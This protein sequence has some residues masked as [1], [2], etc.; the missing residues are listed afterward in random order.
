MR[1]RLGNQKPY[2]A[3]HCIYDL[4]PKSMSQEPDGLV[5][6]LRLKGLAN[7]NFPLMLL[8]VANGIWMHTFT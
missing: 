1:T 6:F 5:N 8:A 2:E 3:M 4:Q 7:G